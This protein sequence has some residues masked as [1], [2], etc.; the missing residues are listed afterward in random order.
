MPLSMKMTG[1]LVVMVFDSGMLQHLRVVKDPGDARCLVEPE[2]QPA[3]Q[4][5]VL[6]VAEEGQTTTIG[7]S[8]TVNDRI[9]NATVHTTSL[10]DRL[11]RC[12]SDM[13]Y[14]AAS[15]TAPAVAMPS[16]VATP[17]RGLRQLNFTRE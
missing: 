11:K 12:I 13:L 9:G 16:P 10:M 4:R 15:A 5:A 6:L 1:R 3:V 14:R 8:W 7:S 2:M 17:E